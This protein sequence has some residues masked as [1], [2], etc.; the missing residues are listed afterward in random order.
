[1][2]KK[3]T[4]E[5]FGRFAE[6]LAAWSLRLKGYRILAR[7]FRCRVG[8]IDIIARRGSLLVFVEVKARRNIAEAAESVRPRQTGRITRASSVFVQGRP[9]LDGLD[10]RFDVIL[11]SPWRWPV[12]LVDAW[13]PE[14]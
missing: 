7:G 9:S 14:S 12:H 6:S 11:V 3:Q 5:K 4:A 13:R 8:E 2:G 1:M 10:Q